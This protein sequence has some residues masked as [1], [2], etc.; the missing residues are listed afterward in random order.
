MSG[1]TTHNAIH[2]KGES[3]V[4]TSQGGKQG[5]SIGERASLGAAVTYSGVE[6]KMKSA[7]LVK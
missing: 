2:F 3:S 6:F 7:E 5:Y 1:K 4:E